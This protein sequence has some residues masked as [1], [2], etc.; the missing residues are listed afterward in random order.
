MVKSSLVKIFVLVVVCMNFVPNDFF[1]PLQFEE[2]VI[3]RHYTPSTKLRYLVVKN[4]RWG[5]VNLILDYFTSWS[6]CEFVVFFKE[7]IF[8]GKLDFGANSQF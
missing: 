3:V 4:S 7:P 6:V 1:Y 8:Y 2:I 5:G